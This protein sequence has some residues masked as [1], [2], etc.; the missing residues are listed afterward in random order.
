MKNFIL[1]F[2]MGLSIPMIGA[3]DPVQMSH[4]KPGPPGCGLKDPRKT[5]PG[6]LSLGQKKIL[7]E[8]G[9]PGRVKPNDHGGLDW[10][11]VRRS[12]SVFGEEEQM[13]SFVFNAQGVL[14]ARDAELIYKKGK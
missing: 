8:R 14:L 10:L 9:T 3:C 7:R 2:L 1:L 12:G 5:A 6:K 11:Y 4:Q 13:E